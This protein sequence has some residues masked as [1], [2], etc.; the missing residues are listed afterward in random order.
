MKSDGIKLSP[1]V[2]EISWVSSTVIWRERFANSRHFRSI[3][4]EG[5][6]D[7]ESNVQNLHIPNS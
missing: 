3:F 1:L 6:L 7:D 2:R 4:A 5:E